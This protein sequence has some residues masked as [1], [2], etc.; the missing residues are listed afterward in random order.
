MEIKNDKSGSFDNIARQYHKP[1]FRYCFHMLRNQQEAE[2]AV[3]EV[4]L[5]AYENYGSQQNLKSVPSWMYK[6]AYHHCLNVIRRKKLLRFIGLEGH[7]YSDIGIPEE[8]IETAEFEEHIQLAL[9]RLS[10]VQRTVLI[11]RTVEEMDYD[12]IAAILC[13]KPQT[14]RKQYERAKKK[15]KLYICIEKGEKYNEEVP[16]IS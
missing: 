5:K 7:L 15:V 2:D 14:V 8:G 6:I 9:S 10:P 12:E 3:Q 1:I 11:L 13:E 16:I 4:F